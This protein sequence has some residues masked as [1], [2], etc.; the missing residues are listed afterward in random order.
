MNFK[1]SETEGVSKYGLMV[2]GMMAIGKMEWPMATDDW[3]MCLVMSMRATGLK[4]KLKGMVFIKLIREADTKDIGR[5]TNKM[6]WVL[7][8]G[9]MAVF[10]KAT[11]KMA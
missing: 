6:E 11:T 10:T 9:Q 7:K 2:L 4:I 5:M 3:F 8:N 1:I